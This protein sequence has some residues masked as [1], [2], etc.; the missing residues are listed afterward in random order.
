MLLA[1]TNR[2]RGGVLVTG[3]PYRH[4]AVLAKMAATVDIASEGRLEL[5]VGAGWFEPEC[6]AYGIELGSITERFDRLEEALVVIRSLFSEP[7]TTFTGRYYRLHDAW[8]EP[9]SAQRP[10]PPIVLGGKGER[11]LLP[12]V[13]RFADHWNYSGDDV[14]EFAR[15]LGRLAELCA[16]AGRDIGELTISANVRA[17]GPDLGRVADEAAAYGDAGAALVC[18]LLPRPY[19]PRL[20]EQLAEVLDPLR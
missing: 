5:G 14:T 11:R 15:L 6:A 16:A 19:D 3:I 9:K 13:A 7:T 18:A 2:I 12:L 17:A 4:P 8:F 20:L 10:H 1:R